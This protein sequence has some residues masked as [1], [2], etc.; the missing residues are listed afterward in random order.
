MKRYWEYMKEYQETVR[1]AKAGD[2]MVFPELWIGFKFLDDNGIENP[3]EQ[4][5]KTRLENILKQYELPERTLF[6]R[7]ING[8]FDAAMEMNER[9]DF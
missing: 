3:W 5:E 6:I 2:S 7:A 1:N 8:T 9:N 4:D